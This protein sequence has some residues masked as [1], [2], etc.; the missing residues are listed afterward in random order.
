MLLCEHMSQVDAKKA[1]TKLIFFAM[2][3]CTRTLCHATGFGRLPERKPNLCDTSLLCIG[4]LLLD[5]LS[6]L[7]SIL[8]PQQG[9]E[10]LGF[11][12]CSGNSNSIG[13][14]DLLG[15]PLKVGVLWSMGSCTGF[16]AIL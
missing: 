5:L 7:S 1:G 6:S 4:I 14:K 2:Q 12:F 9:S 3:F 15:M 13:A 10:M 8:C 11:A 16:W